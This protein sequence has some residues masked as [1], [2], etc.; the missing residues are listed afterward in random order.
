MK[1]KF[2]AFI[3][4]LILMI[5][6]AFIYPNLITWGDGQLLHQISSIGV[7][8][9]F[10]FY[11][12]KLSYQQIREGL[13]NWKLHIAIQC[14]TFVLFPIIL[15]LAKPFAQT[16]LQ[17]QFWLS[18]FFLAV[19]PSTVSSSVVMV[20]IARGN[21]PAA[22]FNASISGLIGVIIS[23]LMMQ[24]FLD[25][26]QEQ[27]VS[28]VYAGLLKEIIIPVIVGLILQPYLGKFASRYGKLLTLFDKSV[29]L[30]IVYI[31]FAESFSSGIFQSVSSWYI[32]WVFVGVIVLFFLIYFIIWFITKY[33]LKFNQEDQI[34]ALFCGS[35]KSLTHGS[36]FGKFI[37]YNNPHAGLYFLPLMIF[38][39][40]QILII[41]WIAQKYGNRINT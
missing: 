4:F 27:V 35:K 16:M 24:V 36:V 29:I 5:V 13:K 25:F 18:F 9:I 11:G 17:E 37:F 2:D 26:E 34:T 20:S 7:T 40:F 32:L 21:V 30:L 1:L 22:I 38:H 39:A 23:P 10:F 33:L 41:T 3:L 12:I 8:L 15:L 14:F 6:F 28:T 19:L 31:S